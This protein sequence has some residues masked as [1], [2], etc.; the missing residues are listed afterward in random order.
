MAI[1]LGGI[2]P[3]GQVQAMRDPTAASNAARK[4]VIERFGMLHP[5][6]YAMV[7]ATAKSTEE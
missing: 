5:S 1:S 3:T 6:N 4:P 7:V 2:V